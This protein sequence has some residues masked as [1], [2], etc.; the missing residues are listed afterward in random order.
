MLTCKELVQQ[1][2]SDYIDKQLSWRQRFGVK[3]HLVLCE[4]CRRFIKQF[5]QVKNLLRTQPAPSM[6]EAQVK[7]LA[8]RL[9]T[10]HC[11]QKKYSP[12]L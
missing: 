10:A 3:I 4:H 5:K 2:A 12:P 11:E 9:H 6:E 7:L 1:Q 8:D